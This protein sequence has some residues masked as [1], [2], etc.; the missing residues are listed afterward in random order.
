MTPKQ[1]PP[2]RLVAGCLSSEEAVRHG[3]FG[4]RGGVSSGLYSSLNCGAG[5]DDAPENVRENRSRIMATLGLPA[6]ALRTVYQVHGRAVVRVDGTE[7]WDTPPKADALVTATPGIALGILT[8]DCVPV[9]FAD[10]QAGVIGAAHAGWKGAL[11]GVVEAALNEMVA[12][13]ARRN[14]I[15]AILGPSIGVDSYE[16]GPDF[17]EPFLMDDGRSKAYFGPS[18]RTGHYMFDLGGYLEDQL[19]RANLGAVERISA[20]TCADGERFFSYRRS[21]RRGEP[22]YGRELSVIALSG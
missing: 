10:T 9:L 11:L 13:G 19:K 12:L 8:A 14:T 21:T 7:L 2:E 4:R 22:D 20:D 18:E 5:S 6:S 1:T 3:F 17:P 15:T 16:V